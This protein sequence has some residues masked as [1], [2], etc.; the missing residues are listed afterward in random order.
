MLLRRA[1][2]LVC[3]WLDG[4]F[5]IQNYLTGTQLSLAAG[6]AEI[7]AA[8]TDWTTGDDAVKALPDLDPESCHAAVAELHSYG[9]L[10]APGESE[11]DDRLAEH[12]QTWSPEAAALH[13]SSK[14]ADYTDSPEINEEFRAGKRSALFK[15]YPDAERIL[16]PRV[17]PDL[18]A[19]FVRTLYGRRTHRGFRQT[20]LQLPRLSQLLAM[21]FGPSEFLDGQDFGAL[22]KRT[23]AAG[24]ARQELE[25]YVAVFAAEGVVPGLYHYNVLEHSLELLDPGFTRERAAHLCY[26]QSAIG[27]AAV[28]VFVTGVVERMS[29]KYRAPRAYRVML[30]NAGHLGQTFALT[31]TA[32]GLGPF[33]TLAF[34]DTE[35]E[36]ALGVDGIRETALYV[37]AAGVPGERPETEYVAGLDAFRKAEL[38]PG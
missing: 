9:F 34:R 21:V 33:Q 37:L 13:F 10:V 3:Y 8:F 26:D 36:D 2:N 15:N 25:A 20:A 14:H 23:S 19:P 27:E 28:T 1:H 32:L 18:D 5:V 38:H 12:W 30:T 7:L 11:H 22:M 16:L 31:A 24:G 35:L 29:S 17:P 4:S 6:A